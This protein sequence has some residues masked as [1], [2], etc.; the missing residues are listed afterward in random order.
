M[1]LI[2]ATYRVKAN[3]ENRAII[4][5][6]MGGGQSLGIGLR[7]RELF[8]WV[9]GM[10]SYLPDAEKTVAEAF[11]EPKR[12]LKLLW[13]ACGT[14]DRLIENARRLSAAL[15]DKNIPHQFK[16]TAGN[17]SWPVWRR[18]LGEFLPLLFTQ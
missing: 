6:S 14:D 12:D 17:H 13:F 1:P 5:L 15:K 7:R 3:R 4:G 2:E 18:Y 9:G 16:E 11:P 10:S 8:A